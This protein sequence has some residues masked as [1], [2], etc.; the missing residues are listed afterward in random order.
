MLLA[1]LTIVNLTKWLHIPL[2]ACSVSLLID[3]R[4]MGKFSSKGNEED[5]LLDVAFFNKLMGLSDPE[6][7]SQALWDAGIHMPESLAACPSEKQAAVV[8]AQH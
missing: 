5:S 1:N 6:L 2:F 3:A 8:F 4:R 7:L